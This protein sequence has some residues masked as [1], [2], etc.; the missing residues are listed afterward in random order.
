M[1]S[2]VLVNILDRYGIGIALLI[3][4]VWGARNFAIWVGSKVVEPLTIRHL[5]FMDSTQS[6]LTKQADAA[7]I[8]A[9]TLVSTAGTLSAMQKLAEDDSRKLSEIH[10]VTMKN[11]TFLDQHGLPV[12]ATSVTGI[13][14]K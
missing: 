14:T 13:Q 1:S 7:V 5:S 4:I 11:I 6:C 12:T 9:N 10:T 8:T 2:E 3:A